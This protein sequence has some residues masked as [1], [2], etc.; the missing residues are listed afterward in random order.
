[1]DNPF[2]SCTIGMKGLP[3]ELITQPLLLLSN[4][5]I[6]RNENSPDNHYSRYRGFLH[7][8]LF[9]CKN[10]GLFKKGLLIG[11][12][13]GPSRFPHFITVIRKQLIS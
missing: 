2:E 13:F 6:N 9:F 3:F 12:G 7:V 4:A 11:I 1:M 8:E 10:L 5:N